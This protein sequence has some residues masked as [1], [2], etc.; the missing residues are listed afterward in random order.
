[1]TDTDLL[2]KA[3]DILSP[4]EMDLN[5]GNFYSILEL[6]ESKSGLHFNKDVFV[7]H[8]KKYLT[9]SREEIFTCTGLFYVVQFIQGFP[10]DETVSL[11]LDAEIVHS[12]KTYQSFAIHHSAEEDEGCDHR[13]HTLQGIQA[14][15]TRVSHRSPGSL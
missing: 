13:L 11:A 15:S 4:D 8:F 6:I 3:F 2:V 7:M 14:C 12:V 1:M 5:E 9:I 10:R